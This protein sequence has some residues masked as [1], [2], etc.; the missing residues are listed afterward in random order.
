MNNFKQKKLNS[1]IHTLV[2]KLSLGTL[3]LLPISVNATTVI[4]DNNIGNYKKT[5]IDIFDDVE[6]N[7]SKTNDSEPHIDIDQNSRAWIGIR[8][9]S[10]KKTTITGDSFK[11]RSQ[12]SK[13]YTD[14]YGIHLGNQTNLVSETDLDINIG[15]GKGIYLA[16]GAM[17]EF[18]GKVN[19]E[20]GNR[21][22]GIHSYTSSVPRRTKG[23]KR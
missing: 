3:A 4:D 11:I 5:G 12:I 8:S 9:S 19:I 15:S 22:I 20:T 10:N 18:R 21:S 14:F 7:I 13:S 23:L 17:G 6:I 16:D 1:I 2:F